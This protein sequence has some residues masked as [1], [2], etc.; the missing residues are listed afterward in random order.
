MMRCLWHFSLL[1]EQHTD[2]SSSLRVACQFSL[3]APKRHRTP[4]YAG[5]LWRGDRQGGVRAGKWLHV[6]PMV[7]K[8]L[9]WGTLTIFSPNHEIIHRHIIEFVFGSL[10]NLDIN[11]NKTHCRLG[12]FSS[13]TDSTAWNNIKVSQMNQSFKLHSVA[14]SLSLFIALYSKPLIDGWVK[15]D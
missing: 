13:M 2:I 5:V 4:L 11:P 8:T 3:R 15:G 1:D 10:P 9:H 14:Y 7:T 12:G 6:E